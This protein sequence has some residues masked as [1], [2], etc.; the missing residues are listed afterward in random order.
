MSENKQHIHIIATGGTIDSVFSPKEYKPIPK[1][2]SGIE[3]FIQNYI[4]PHFETSLSTVSMI[5]SLYMT[6]DIRADI[7]KIIEESNQNLILITHGTDGM[8][9]SAKYI[10]QNLKDKNKTII[11][12]GS[13]IPLTGFSPSDAGFNLGFAIG[14]L[15][16]LISGVYISMNGKIF[17][18]DN[19]QK[20]I[21]KSRFEFKEN[22]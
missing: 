18:P 6:D 3:E 2:S 1:E 7:L 10:E 21:D 22:S 8:I 13:M 19:V 20:N 9:D 15:L 17:T 12:I 16:N 11:F 4:K 14:N 5:D